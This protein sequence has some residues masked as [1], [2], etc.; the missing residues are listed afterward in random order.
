MA[1]DADAGRILITNASGETRLD[2]NQDLFHT[3][4]SSIVGTE[5]IAARTRTA[6]GDLRVNETND[7]LIG[8]CHADCTLVIG[9]VKMAATGSF[10]I[11]YSRWTTYM[12]GELVWAMTAPALVGGGGMGVAP[13]TVCTYRFFISSGD[14][15]LRQRLV[16]PSME[17]LAG[18]TTYTL[19]AHT[20]DY[21]LECGLFT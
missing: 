21:N 3:I 2:T 8:T 12:G 1:F 17:F 6:T 20:I 14:V 10:G 13:H 7:T 9:A 5:S 11:G 18:G 19:V 4:G 15:Y 16:M